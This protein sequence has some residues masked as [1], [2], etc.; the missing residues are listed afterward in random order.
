MNEVTYFLVKKGCVY[1]LFTLEQVKP[2]NKITQIVNTISSSPSQIATAQRYHGH[3]LPFN[4]YLIG[5][6]G[7]D[8]HI[9]TYSDQGWNE[10]DV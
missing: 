3:L 2:N 7:D 8:M 1:L 4:T 10:F 9:T 6:S 5:S